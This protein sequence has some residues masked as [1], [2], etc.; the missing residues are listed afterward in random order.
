MRRTFLLASLILGLAAFTAAFAATAG[1]DSTGKITFEPSQGYVVGDING[2]MGWSKT[3][4]YD[5][6]VATVSAFPAATKYHFGLQALRLSDAVTSGSFGD[7]TFSPGLT[8]PAGESPLKTR[9]RASFSIGTALST[10]Q[11]G[12]HMSVSPD[13]GSGARMS[14]LRFEDQTN[15]V[16]V[17]FDDVTNNGPVGTVSTFNETDI[18]TLSRA[19]DHQIRF[20]I[21]F[22][23]GPGND[24]VRIF[25]D[26]HKTTG[27]T[28]E[29]Y[30]RYD[31]E[32][33]GNGN[34]VSP[35]SKM[36]FRES[37]TANTG[38][39][40]KGFLVDGLSLTSSH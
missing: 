21:T 34:M 27:T 4:P 15:G 30:Y 35:V 14:Y 22:K 37:G 1:A 2:Q 16:H 8:Q 28:W 23:P 11:S 12:L 10:E 24:V 36:L 19:K 25:I 38:N 33:T 29:N 17:F 18:A 31:P 20:S 9:F 26:G 32:A 6:A 3:G 5:V 13:N 39:L 7:Q 40:N